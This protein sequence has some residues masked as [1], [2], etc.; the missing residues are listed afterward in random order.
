MEI[1]INIT[2]DSKIDPLKDHVVKIL[3]LS[4]VLSWF[5]F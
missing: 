5:F 4:S 2:L 1:I 3:V